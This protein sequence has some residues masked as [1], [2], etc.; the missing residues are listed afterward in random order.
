MEYKLVIK[1]AVNPEIRHKIEK[2]LQK[3]GFKVHGGGTHS[4][5]S[6]CDTTFSLDD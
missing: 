2:L 6:S 3:E 1:P 4:D 5:M